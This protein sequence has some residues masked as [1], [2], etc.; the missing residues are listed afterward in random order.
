VVAGSPFNKKPSGKF[1]KI[2]AVM[3]KSRRSS[4]KWSAGFCFFPPAVS[5]RDC[6]QEET[7]RSREILADAR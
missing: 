7:M 6:R 3:D 2:T 1:Q 4:K 5:D